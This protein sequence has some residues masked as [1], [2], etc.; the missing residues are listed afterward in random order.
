[1]AVI[2]LAGAIASFLIA[3]YLLIDS[4]FSMGLGNFGLISCLQGYLY[5][6]NQIVGTLLL[7]FAIGLVLLAVGVFI[8]DRSRN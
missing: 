8:A 6:G 2:H 5:C 1:M 3:G 4:V 7:K